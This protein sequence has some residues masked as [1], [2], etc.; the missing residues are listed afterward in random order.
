MLP[1]VNFGHKEA[2]T[3]IGLINKDVQMNL[4]KDVQ[5]N[6]CKS[7]LRKRGTVI[8]QAGVELYLLCSVV[9]L[10]K[11]IPTLAPGLKASL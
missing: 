4:C 11:C 3:L 7:L 5:M 2:K 10:S 8:F 1:W 9:H 6:L